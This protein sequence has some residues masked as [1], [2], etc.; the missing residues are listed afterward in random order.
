MIALSSRL[1]LSR[2]KTNRSGLDVLA[3]IA[4]AVTTLLALTVAGGTTMFVSRMQNPPAALEALTAQSPYPTS[5]ADVAGL[6]VDL[7][8]I[9]C[10]ILVVPILSLGGGAARLGASGRAKRL[11][12]LR[13][14]G[15]TGAEVTLM[16]VIESLVLTLAGAVLGGLV[17]ALT[18]PIWQFVSFH[19]ENLSPR[20]MLGPW[21]LNLAVLAVILILSAISTIIGLSRVVISPLGVA[22]RETPKALQFWRFIVFVGAIAVFLVAV[23]NFN[24]FSSQIFAFL[25]I[26]GLLAFV[27]FALSLVGP[28]VI[29]LAARP[30]LHTSNAATLLASR[31]LMAQPRDAWRNVGGLAFI[32]FISAFTVTVPQVP[33]DPVFNLQL[34]DIG[35]G[36][37]LTLI[38]GLLVAATSTL[39]N[40]AAFTVDRADQT[41][42]LTRMGTP[43]RVFDGARFRQVLIPLV[44]TLGISVPLGIYLIRTFLNGTPE[45]ATASSGGGTLA[46]I[47]GLGVALCLGAAAA[48]RPIESKIL[49]SD[50]RRND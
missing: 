43:R 2:I 40:Q 41:V 10:A 24:V 42:A 16:S 13:L 21:W 7:A 12:S 14:I 35:M 26:G 31:R 32:G 8:V 39:I 15:M 22:R 49:T 11:A 34:E 45:L 6:Y 29:Q 28:W 20:E 17:F 47:I 1:A 30:F 3:V 36:T 38:I 37:L 25:M 44:T 48:S 9:A 23:Q 46:V 19:G 18:L 5:A 33:D 27:L 50:Y 4:F